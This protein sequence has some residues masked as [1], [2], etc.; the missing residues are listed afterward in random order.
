HHNEINFDQHMDV[1]HKD[2][3]DFQIIKHNR[4]S[5]K[6]LTN[7]KDEHTQARTIIN[8]KF[9]TDK[10]L[11]TSISSLKNYNLNDIEIHMLK[12]ALDYAVEYCY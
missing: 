10:N 3:F 4:Q 9:Y 7:D 5:K 12:H 11:R 6:S 2:D 1:Y 8:S